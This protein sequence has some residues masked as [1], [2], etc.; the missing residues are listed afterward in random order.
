MERGV[1]GER[2]IERDD[3]G[4]VRVGHTIEG[5]HAVLSPNP[6][7]YSLENTALHE[8]ANSP[9][10]FETSLAICPITPVD[11]ELLISH[12]ACTREELTMC[13]CV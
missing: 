8:I 3:G 12:A 9:T 6:F 1:D 5:V 4:W 2:F 11:V 7:P 10:S 13:V